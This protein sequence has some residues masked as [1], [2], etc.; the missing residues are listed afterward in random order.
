MSEVKDRPR[1]AHLLREWRRRRKLSQFDLALGAGVSP[2]HLSFIETGRSRPSAAMILQLSDHL[3]IPLRERNALLLAAGHAPVYEQ[4]DLEDPEMGPVREALDRILRGHEPFPALVVD[5]HWGLV[6]ANRGLGLLLGG[7]NETLLAPPVNV[8]RLTFH[9]DGLAPRIRN[10]AEWRTHILD[11][12]LRQ[13]LASGDPALD[14]L[15]RELLDYP[16]PT[17]DRLP[18][19]EA[20]SIAVPLELE[21]DGTVLSFISTATVFGTAVDV[22]LSELAIESFFPADERTARFLRQRL[23]R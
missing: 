10:L 17:P 11:R 1:F 6:A 20:G 8:L 19:L 9:P 7:V 3:E 4:H 18:D 21:A 12:L 22:T 5:R 15:Y 16:A 2:R 23:G 14:T 13:S